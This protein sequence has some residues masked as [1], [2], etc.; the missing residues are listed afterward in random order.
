MSTT[1]L[2][3]QMWDNEWKEAEDFVLLVQNSSLGFP[4]HDN[5]DNP[6]LEPAVQATENIPEVR[7]APIQH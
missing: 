3:D 2:D 6:S 5:K 7:S 4:R 1:W